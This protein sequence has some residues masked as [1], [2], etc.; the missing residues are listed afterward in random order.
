MTTINFELD[1]TNAKQEEALFN[2]LLNL[3]LSD[4]NVAQIVTLA[5]LCSYSREGIRHYHHQLLKEITTD[6]SKYIATIFHS[7]LNFGNSNSLKLELICALYKSQQLSETLLSN[8]L[9]GFASSKD[10]LTLEL[11]KHQFAHTN[12]V[13]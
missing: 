13:Q 12:T 3:G 9:E 8:I 6:D 10:R 4:N 5:R 2:E 7:L 1:H 11:T